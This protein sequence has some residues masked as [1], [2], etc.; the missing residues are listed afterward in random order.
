MQGKTTQNSVVTL[1]KIT[2][3][4]YTA[5]MRDDFYVSYIKVQY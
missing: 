2:N 4:D 3:M 1:S 5:Y